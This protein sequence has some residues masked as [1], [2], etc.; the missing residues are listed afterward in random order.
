MQYA[1]QLHIG[2]T[3]ET[4]YE[5]LTDAKQLEVWFAEHADV[6]LPDGRYEFWGRYTPGGER[7]RQRLLEAAPGQRLRFAWQLDGA[8]RTV[9]LALVE[10]GGTVLTVTEVDSAGEPVFVNASFWGMALA[11]LASHVEGH[12]VPRRTPLRPTRSST[13]HRRRCS[14]HCS[15][16]SSSA[17]G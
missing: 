6:S 7:G 9:E 5:A 8:E 15:T 1:A 17:G 2:A 13:R 4:V 16:R 14:P 11:N 10:E 12:S 3:P